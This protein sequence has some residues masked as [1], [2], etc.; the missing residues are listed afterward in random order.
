MSSVS[1]L[2]V[3]YSTGFVG[4]GTTL[5]NTAFQIRTNTT[6]PGTII[7]QV[8]TGAI[9]DIRDAGSSKV[10]VDANGNVGIGTTLPTAKLEIFGE[11]KSSKYLFSGFRT[12]EYLPTVSA[13]GL[14]VPYYAVYNNG[15]SYWKNNNYYEVPVSGFYFIAYN[16]MCYGST[17]DLYSKIQTMDTNGNI[18]RVSDNYY[19][20]GSG[21]YDSLGLT[22]ILYASTGERIYIWANR[23]PSGTSWL[24]ASHGN[25]CIYLLN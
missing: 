9:L 20:S 2:K 6:T 10:I 11:L 12:N 3:D 23:Y 21:G 5:P 17:G 4:I 24:H 15:S 25:I 19:R 1:G 8:G 16:Y 22:F 7:D 14:Y 13:T 18:V